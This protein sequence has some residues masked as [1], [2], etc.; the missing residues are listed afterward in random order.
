MFLI[1]SK[2]KIRL[3]TLTIMV[4][5]LSD[6][7]MSNPEDETCDYKLVAPRS[8]LHIVDRNTM[9]IVKTVVLN[10]KDLIPYDIYSDIA[11]KRY[12]GLIVPQ[13]GQPCLVLSLIHI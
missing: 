12:I 5:S 6:P 1:N 8:H 13:I 4:S 7:L 9:N 2:N 3:P 11:G 10:F